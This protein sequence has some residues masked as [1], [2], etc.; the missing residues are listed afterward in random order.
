MDKAP[1]SQAYGPPGSSSDLGRCSCTL[2]CQLDMS[3]MYVYSAHAKEKGQ[4]EKNYAESAK[5]QQVSCCD[6][7]SSSAIKSNE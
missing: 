7:W 1:V 2:S 5:A 4:R 3:C 6:L